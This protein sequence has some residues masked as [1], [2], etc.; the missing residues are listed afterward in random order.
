MK[1]NIRKSL[2]PEGEI[3]PL[4]YDFMFSQIFNN[5]ENIEIVEGFVSSY[6]DLPLDKVHNKVEIKSRNL[7]I[8]NKK[9]ANNE[10]DLLLELE[11]KEKINIEISTDVS[12]GIKDRNI[13][14]LSKIHSKNLE[15]GMNDYTKIY[16]SIQINLVSHNINEKNMIESYYLR[17]EEGKKL[18][19]KLQI[20]YIDMA[21]AREVCY[22]EGTREEKIRKWCEIIMSNKKNEF[23][24]VLKESN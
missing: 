1:K 4:K 12:E 10:V 3:I 9:E 15:Y 11:T 17:N 14:F 6:F 23:E 21:K 7:N 22:N 2:L 5:P 19:E 20:D 13:V 8:E 16:P 24:K 18:T